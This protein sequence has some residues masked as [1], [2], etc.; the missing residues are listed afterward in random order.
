[1]RCARDVAAANAEVRECRSED[2]AGD[3]ESIGPGLDEIEGRE[4]RCLSGTFSD[5]GAI[6]GH[7]RPTAVNG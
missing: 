7:D 6:V 2:I 4:Q 5:G 1:M 3:G